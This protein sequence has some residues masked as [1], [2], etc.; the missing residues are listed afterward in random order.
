MRHVHFVAG[1]DQEARFVHYFC[2]D[3]ID[4]AADPAEMIGRQLGSRARTDDDA[5]RLR[6]TFSECVLTGDP[7]EC[8]ITDDVSGVIQCRFE[9]VVQRRD[10]AFHSDDEVVAIAVA[11]QLPG[12]IDLSQR[13]QQI[14]RLICQDKSN[15]EIA[16]AL[17]LAGSTVET[18]RQNIRKKIGAGGT[19]GIVLYAVQHG[20][21][22]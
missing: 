21:V 22:D 6:S 8:V 17:K 1:L 11:C 9:K 16:A 13:E 12:D 4:L 20:L 15:S 7:Q 19:A 14:V 3:S 5:R 10:R 2:C 18:H